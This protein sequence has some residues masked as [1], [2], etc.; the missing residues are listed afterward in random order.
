[1]RV[2][3]GVGLL[4]CLF[5]VA[6]L[7]VAQSPNGTVSGIVLDPSGGVIVGA[8][9]LIINNATGVEYPGKANS[10]GYYV[11]PNIPPG[12][13]RI[14]V[15]SSGF[16]TII[17]PDIV[18]H[19]EDALAINFTLP[20]GAASEI[21]T[22]QGGAPMLDTQDAAVGTVIDRQFAENLPMNGR[23]FQT[24]IELTPGV[25]LT[26]SYQGAEGQFSVNG[27]RTTSNAWIVDGV[28]ANI[29]MGANA[30]GGNGV[31]GALGS[32]SVLGGTNSLVSVD[33]LQEFRIETSTYAPEFGRTPGAQ[34]SIVTRSGSDTF[35]GT[36]FDY[37]RNSDLDANNWF[38]DQANL[39]KP[40]ERQ[41]DFGGTFSGPILKDRTFFFF[42]YE[43]LRLTVPQ[44]AF[45]TVPDLNARQSAAPALQPFLNAYPLPNGSDDPTTGIGQFNASYS[46]PAR[47]D[48]SSLRIDHKLSDRFSLFGRY[49]YS[50]S[51]ASDRGSSTL[52]P[53][54]DVL[55]ASITVQT[56]TAGLI[57]AP[58]ASISDDFRFNYSNTHAASSFTIDNFG[59]AVPLVALPLPNGYSN[60]NALLTFTIYALAHPYLSDGASATNVQRQINLINGL[61]L[62]KGAHNLKLGVDYR[63]LMPSFDPALYVQQPIFLDV[64]SAVANNPLGSFVNAARNSKLIFQNLGIFAQDTWHILPRLSLTYGLRWDFDFDPSSAGGAALPAVTGY[65]L[66]NL[67][68]LALA[69]AGT[70]PFKTTY[71][72]VAPRLGLAYQLSQNSTWGSVL[73]GGFGVFYDL[74]TSQVGDAIGTNYPFGASKIVYGPPYGGT[75]TFPLGAAEAAPPTITPENLALPG[76]V[77]TALDPHL[78]LPYTLEWSVALQQALGSQQSITASYIGSTGRRLI[79]SAYISAPNANFYSANL[80]GNTAR[81]DYNALQVQFQRRLS[82]GLQALASYT[83]SHSIDDGSNG[84]YGIGSNSF[85]PGSSNQSRGPSDF[86][87]RNTFSAGLTYDIPG[88]RGN[89]LT[90][91]IL[92]GWSVENVIQ[93][94]SAAPVNVYYSEFDLLSGAYTLVRPDLV[95]GVPVYLYGAQYPGGMAFNPA[96]FTAPPVAANGNPIRQGTLGR[97]ALRGFGAAQW[98]FAVHRDFPIHESIKLQFRAELFNVVNHPNFAPPIG[99]LQNPESVNAQFG[100][101]TQTLGQYLGNTNVGGGGLS[102]L[103]QIGG[104]RSVQLALK[105]VF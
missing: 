8:N 103:Y 105:L 95:A 17:K 55:N 10:E 71:G 102:T 2:N 53:L 94:W 74:A 76:G 35:H 25:V 31:A 20:I 26:P 85:V 22:V 33:A 29:G 104:P 100:V 61:S 6:S 67:S 81:S 24:L 91:A 51:S 14:Q 83:W 37:L 49:N 43:G 90:S 72:N 15:S 11:V 70:S 101:S 52:Y 64:E 96:A 57:W 98:D 50:P 86:D 69:P 1:M 40:A 65:D 56:G 60:K 44:T 58:T 34:I 80:I 7:S 46:N 4:V 21:V 89:V 59:G 18:I 13:Y 9:V 79:Q 38:A 45:T 68:N 30:N 16:K 54:S 87:H 93:A 75:A 47:L 39:Q 73:R 84:S 23:S 28:S 88:P 99:D 3:R 19:V 32:F 5:L 48:A 78:K 92:H 41:N 42:S 27:Q 77:L 62:Q 63:R 36:M 97:N 12:T 66:S 82:S